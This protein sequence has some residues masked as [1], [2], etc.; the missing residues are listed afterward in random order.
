[1]ANKSKVISAIV[2]AILFVSVISGTVFYY[3]GRIANLNSEILKLKGEIANFPTPNL[4]ATLGIAEI[5][6][7]ESSYMGGL[8]PT[9][10]QYNYLY[11]T[12]YV[13]NTGE[14]TAYNAGL[15]VVACDATGQLQINMTVPFGGI[16]GTDNST[17]AFVLQNYGS[18][19]PVLQVYT[20]NYS[21]KLGIIDGEQTAYINDA[22]SIL[23]EGKVAN[24][25][26]TP[27]WTNTP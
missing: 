5:L 19:N 11:I 10:I 21:S 22:I 4:T 2:I 3:N 9:P 6:G 14:G 27:V 17:D 12:G 25:T 1:M 16:F 24:W 15:H 23:H 20:S 7:N 8:A 13:N 18:Y 26:I